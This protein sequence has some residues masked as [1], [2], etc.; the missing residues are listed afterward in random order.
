MKHAQL[1]SHAVHIGVFSLSVAA[2]M[3]VGGGM[4]VDNQHIKEDAFIALPKN[5]W[6]QYLVSPHLEC[7]KKN[8]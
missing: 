1:L 5:H 2:G 7:L 4:R 8:R 3:S 6:Q